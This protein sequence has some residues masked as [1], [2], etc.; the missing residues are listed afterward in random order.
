[1]ASAMWDGIRRK[2]TR[3]A[4]GPAGSVYLGMTTGENGLNL[5]LG[6]DGLIGASLCETL[7]KRGRNVCRTTRHPERIDGRDRFFL[8]LEEP[9]PIALPAV[10][11][12]VYVC[13]S[14]ARL[15]DCENDPRYTGRINVHNTLRV[16]EQFPHAFA[17]FISST[18]VFNGNTLLPGSGDPTDPVTEYGRQ[19][20]QVEDALRTRGN[21]GILRLA[22]VAESLRP[23]FRDWVAAWNPGQP[24]NAF[25][26]MVMA[27]VPLDVTVD[28]L[29][30]IADRKEPHID[31]LSGEEDISY[32]YAARIGA[33]EL[34]VS[35]DLIASTSWRDA[36]IIPQ[37][38][39]H[40]RLDCAASCKDLKL[41]IPP[42]PNTVRNVFRQIL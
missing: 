38:P 26:D 12:V 29:I 39:A 36:G 28:V 16:L 42:V 34:G 30:R 19:K 21:A 6:G 2:R 31:H 18:Q 22:K 25:R 27:P 15:R 10:P 14:I 23:L 35:P 3:F 37:P 41:T 1:M 20:V 4:S 33:D 8:D 32:E 5:I 11:E 40:T 7:R 13:A 9:Q 24:V 17:V